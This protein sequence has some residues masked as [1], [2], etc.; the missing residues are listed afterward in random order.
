MDDIGFMLGQ[1]SSRLNAIEDTLK[2]NTEKL[3]RILSVTD[4]AKGSWRTLTV[5]GGSLALL[6]EAMHQLWHWL[7]QWV[8]IK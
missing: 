6:V 5:I 3:D 2:E 1:H 8:A 4:Q 7:Q